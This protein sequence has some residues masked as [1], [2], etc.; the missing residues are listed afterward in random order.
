VKENGHRAP[1]TEGRT[2]PR[3]GRREAA[4]PHSRPL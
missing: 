2:P 4:R 1:G 3:H